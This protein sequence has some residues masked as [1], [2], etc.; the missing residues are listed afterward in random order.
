MRGS[1]TNV[2]VTPLLL[3]S[4]LLLFLFFFF[5]CLFLV[6]GSL[7]RFL[8]LRLILKKSLLAQACG[9][10]VLLT[11]N[12]PEVLDLLRE[13]TRGNVLEHH[14]TVTKNN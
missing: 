8:R 7:G 10:D 1:W 9:D 3:P 12:Q 5:A 14:A 4:P 13:N 11:D 2:C 6:L